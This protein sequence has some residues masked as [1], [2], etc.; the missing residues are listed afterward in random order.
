MVS[1]L[2]RCCRRAASADRSCSPSEGISPPTTTSSSATSTRRSS[3]STPA[4]SPTLEGGLTPLAAARSHS[5]THPSLAVSCSV[6]LSPRSRKVVAST[7]RATKFTIISSSTFTA[8]SRSLTPPPRRRLPRRLSSSRRLSRARTMRR[9]RRQFKRRRRPR[10][11]S[12]RSMSARWTMPSGQRA[13]CGLPRCAS[14]G[15]PR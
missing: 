3:S 11:P 6:T 4:S 12:S 13:A 10:T 15:G 1:L 8:S 5:L 2:L 9:D 7:K 14:H